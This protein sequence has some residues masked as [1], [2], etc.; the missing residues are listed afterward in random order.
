MSETRVFEIAAF[1]LPSAGE[2]LR[3][4]ISETP[5]ATVVSWFVLPGQRIAAH[6]HP[7]GQDSWTLLSGGGDYQTDAAGSCVPIAA[8][9]VVVARRGQVHGVVNT[10]AV[11]LA[12]VSVVCPGEAGYEPL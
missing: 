5:D 3:T 9:Q 2:P 7:Q 12:F 8:G 11:P 10:G 6:I 4:V 1:Q